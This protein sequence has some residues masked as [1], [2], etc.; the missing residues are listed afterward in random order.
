MLA[1]CGE[2]E[3]QTDNKQESSVVKSEAD[4]K[5]A[6]K[7]NA[8][9]VEKPV[10]T[11]YIL[12]NAPAGMDIVEAKVN[13]M[14]EGKLD[15]TVDFV[16]PGNLNEKIN[17]MATA[18]E[19]FDLLFSAS[20]M[21]PNYLT[22]SRKGALVEL[23]DLLEQYGSAIKE[24][25]PQEILDGVM[26]DGGLYAIPNYQSNVRDNQ[27]VMDKGLAEQYGLDLD[28]LKGSG[29]DGTFRDKME[30]VLETIKQKDP[31]IIPLDHSNWATMLLSDIEQVSGASTM[32]GV[33]IKSGEIIPMTEF[34]K[35]WA[36]VAC[37]WYDKGYI[38]EDVATVTDHSADV[39]AGRYAVHFATDKRE[40]N[41]VN[42]A[43]TYGIQGEVVNVD[44][45]E[46]YVMNGATMSSMTAISA[47]SKNSDLAIQ[48]I[49]ILFEDPEIYNTILWGVEGI[50]WNLND[51]GTIKR[52][53]EGKNYAVDGWRVAGSTYNTLVVEG[54]NPELPK[55]EKE[56]GQNVKTSILSGWNFDDA[57]VTV[58]MANVKT[59]NKEYAHLFN[60]S[61]GMENFEAEWAKYEKA[62][63]AAGYQKVYGEM[64][65]QIEEF[66]AGK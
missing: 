55:L 28:S 61:C 40:G 17:M 5:E 46:R 50:H 26:V 37:D 65:K 32:I 16:C 57:N 60:G 13:E 15:A 4:D 19:E 34:R 56:Y 14:L 25:V 3:V 23:S 21:N 59:V 54:N 47:T 9:P 6:E 44:L 66:L 30:V 2:K 29:W 51:D 10:L 11:W 45:M 33:D 36:E 39:K 27:L 22:L 35:E 18:G 42:F 43:T 12:D 49:N 8:K 38:R 41:R 63:D 58:E 64:M 31:A 24:T 52:T 7:N 48:L 62:L 20:W 1:G 53:E